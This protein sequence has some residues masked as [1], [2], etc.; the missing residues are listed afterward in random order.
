QRRIVR[1]ALRSELLVM[2]MRGQAFSQR[3]AQH[4]QNREGRPNWRCEAAS[5]M[6][7]RGE[8]CGRAMRSI[9]HDFCSMTRTA[10]LVLEPVHLCLPP[11]PLQ[12]I[13]SRAWHRISNDMIHMLQ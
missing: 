12:S 5:P 3:L 1:D 2:A 8:V 6:R 10:V 7:G 4:A 9:S 13:L 11:T